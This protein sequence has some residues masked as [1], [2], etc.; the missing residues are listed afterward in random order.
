MK[1]IKKNKINLD[2]S[3]IPALCSFRF[4]DKNN[5]ICKTI[6]TQEMLKEAFLQQI[7]FMFVQSIKKKL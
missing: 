1:K 4:K 3:G 5:N 2:I 7:L 6:I